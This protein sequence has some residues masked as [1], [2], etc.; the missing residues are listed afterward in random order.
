MAFEKVEYDFLVTFSWMRLIFLKNYPTEAE[1]ENSVQAT[2]FEKFSCRN[3]DSLY[4][5]KI[6]L[7]FLRIF[8]YLKPFHFYLY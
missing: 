6:N 2:S 4:F 3:G 8:H 5:C 7:M 1:I